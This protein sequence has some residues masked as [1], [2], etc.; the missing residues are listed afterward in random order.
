MASSN[1][2]SRNLPAAGCSAS[3]DSATGGSSDIDLAKLFEPWGIA[4]AIKAKAGSPADK[5]AASLVCVLS[6]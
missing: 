6:V 4:D 3:L 1:F 5:Q 2:G